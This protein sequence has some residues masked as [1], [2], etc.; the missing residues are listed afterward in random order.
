VLMTTI[1]FQRS[2][3]GAMTKYTREDP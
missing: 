2:T 3:Q 1:Q